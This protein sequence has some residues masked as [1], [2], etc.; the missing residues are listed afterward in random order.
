MTPR[1]RPLSFKVIDCTQFVNTLFEAAGGRQIGADLTAK[2]RNTLLP[3]RC[4]RS[5]IKIKAPPKSVSRRVEYS[6][7]FSVK[8]FHSFGNTLYLIN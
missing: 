7:I 6:F 5:K 1:C 2:L 4:G 8:A 3:Y